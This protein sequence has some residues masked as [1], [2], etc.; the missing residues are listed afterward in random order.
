MDEHDWIRDPD[1]RGEGLICRC[2][3]LT[4]AEAEATPG[5]TSSCRYFGEAWMIEAE[6]GSTST[7]A[8]V[9]SAGEAYS[10]AQAEGLA[11]A[12]LDEED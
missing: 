12:D 6:S 9:E 10:T 4:E 8:W 3:G 7:G 5:D 11:A 1:R 2:C